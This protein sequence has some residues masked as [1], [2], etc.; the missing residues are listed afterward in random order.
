MTVTH[1]IVPHYF[2]RRMTLACSLTSCG[3][4]I[5]LIVMPL[6]LTLLIDEYSFRGAALITGALSLN[7]CAASMVFH[8][9]E[10]HSNVQPTKAATQKDI[11]GDGTISRVFKSIGRMLQTARGN[12]WLFRSVRAILINAILSVNTMAFNNFLYLVPFAMEDAGNSAE[13]AGLSISVAGTSLFVTRIV[14]PIVFI[15]CKMRHQ[16]GVMSSSV[17]IGTSIVGEGLSVCSSVRYVAYLCC[18]HYQII[19]SMIGRLYAEKIPN[20]PNSPIAVTH[21]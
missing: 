18:V 7:C 19:G 5:S 6:L 2:T 12:L 21:T 16:V 9:I 1:A 10:W 11:E 4:S 20:P 3:S 14:Y 13:E 17:I 15:R 8:P